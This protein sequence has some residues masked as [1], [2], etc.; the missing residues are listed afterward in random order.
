MR[1]PAIV[2]ALALTLSGCT[3]FLHTV[4]DEPIQPDPHNTSLGTDIDDFQIE[5]AVGVN[6]KK[7][8]PLLAN[9]HV[10]VHSYNGVVLLTGEVPSTEMRTLAGD[11]ARNFRGVRQV[12]NELQIQG[13][14]SFLSRTND[15]WLTTKVKSKLIADKTVESGKIKV[16]TENGVV[17]LMGLTSQEI[18]NKAAQIAST[19]KG[20]RKVVKVF[21]YSGQ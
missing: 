14:T 9:A 15:G 17:Y 5:T 7:Q 13:A 21:E 6:I 1:K 4:K 8:H 19:T 2:V 20:V 10:N 3:S 11:T 18:A 12:H 16:I